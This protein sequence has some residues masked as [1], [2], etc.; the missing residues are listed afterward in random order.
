MS[1]VSCWW[2]ALC[3]RARV[4]YSLI[5]LVLWLTLFTRADDGPLRRRGYGSY[6]LYLPTIR[7]SA[8]C[9][10]GWHDCSC[11]YGPTFVV[12][13]IKEKKSKVQ[14][15]CARVSILTSKKL[16]F[17]WW[18]VV[19]PNRALLTRSQLT[20]T[21]PSSSWAGAATSRRQRVEVANLKLTM[22]FFLSILYV[23]P[24]CHF[25]LASKSKMVKDFFQMMDCVM[26]LDQTALRLLTLLCERWAEM[27]KRW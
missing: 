21:L 7:R 9:V 5:V 24:A 16:F 6:V 14:V 2:F 13:F 1:I 22:A 11:V 18:V 10:Y 8:V 26:W 25:W 15:V 12:G 27:E 4:W 17:M 19:R 23:C 3:V 20:R